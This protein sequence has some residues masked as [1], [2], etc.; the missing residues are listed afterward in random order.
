MRILVTLDVL[1]VRKALNQCGRTALVAVNQ[2]KVA[3]VCHRFVQMGGKGLS[4]TCLTAVLG[5]VS[6]HL[7]PKFLCAASLFQFVLITASVPY[8]WKVK[9]TENRTAYATS[10]GLVLVV[11]SPGL[12][13]AVEIRICRL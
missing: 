2:S 9:Q 13:Q 7:L 12:V 5:R 1:R 10:S 8:R 4:V 6:R 11:S 3:V